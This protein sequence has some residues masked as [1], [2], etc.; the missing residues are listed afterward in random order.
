MA[1]IA[2][3]PPTLKT[4]STPALRA[5]TSTAGSA[6]PLRVG[7][8]HMTRTGQPAI[9]AGTASM[10]ALE[11]SGAEPAGTYSPTAR[12]GT[13]MRSHSTPREVSMRSGA[14][15][16]R[17]SAAANSRADT[18]NSSSRTPSNLWV[19]SMSAASPL[20]RTSSMI[21]RVAIVTRSASRCAGRRKASRRC[22]TARNFQ[23]RTRMRKTLAP[24][25]QHFLDR[26][27]QHRARAHALQILEGFPEHVFAAYRMHG[28]PIAEPVERNDR[29]CFAAGQQLGDRGKRGAGRVQHDVLA[30]LHLLD[31]VDAHQQ[32]ARPVLLLGGDGHRSSNEH[33]LTLEH[34]LGLA[35]MIGRERRAGGDQIADQ[36]GPPEA[37][38]D[39]DRAG[40]HYDF[41]ANGALGEKSPEYVRIGGRDALAIERGR[42]PVV[43]S[44][45]C[46]DAQLAVAEIQG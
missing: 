36:V 11:G 40:Q 22:D 37:G 7:A 1:A 20:R 2:C 27:H 24:S 28:N 4:C 45:G 42:A 32:P 43:E 16:K 21:S 38:R 8:V 6:P 44:V 35:Q 13:L 5:A 23:S 34:H 9:A 17:R 33:R 26:Q 30:A 29:R 10:M 31:A 15:L 41:R 19:N 39:L 25:G 14:A 3:A 18:A 46:R 12:T